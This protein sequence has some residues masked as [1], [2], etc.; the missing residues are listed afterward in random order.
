LLIVRHAAGG[1]GTEL[2]VANSGN[3]YADNTQGQWW[4]WN[5]SGWGGA[6]NP[7]GSLS[8]DGSAPTPPN[9]SFQFSDVTLVNDLT[10]YTAHG[11]NYDTSAAAQLDNA[12]IW[13]VPAG[14]VAIGPNSQTN[15]VFPTT[16]P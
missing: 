9:S 13:G 3:L 2:E 6:T 16:H 4:E 5:G 10:Q 15:D 7:N 12:Q 1:W 11:I 8:S 14:N